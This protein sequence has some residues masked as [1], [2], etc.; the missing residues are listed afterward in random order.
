MSQTVLV[1]GTFCDPWWGF[2]YPGV[3]PGQAV[4][5][6]ESTTRFAWNAGLGIEYPLNTGSVVYIDVRYHE[7]QTQQNTPFIPIQFGVRF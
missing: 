6:E 1:A 7:L 2:C 5:A 3:A 4:V